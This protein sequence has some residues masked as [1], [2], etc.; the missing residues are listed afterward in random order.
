MAPPISEGGCMMN[1]ESNRIGNGMIAVGVLL[2]ILGLAAYFYG[3][4]TVILGVI[5]ATTY[6][7]R[8]I[9]TIMLIIGSITAIVGAVAG[10]PSA[11]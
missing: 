1:G 8:E 11:R 2:A 5:V 9:G 7:H 6:P 4:D 3:E 10:R